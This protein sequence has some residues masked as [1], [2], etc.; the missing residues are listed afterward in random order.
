MS[1]SEDSTV[2]VTKT[3]GAKYGTEEVAE[4][5]DVIAVH[6]FET[7]TA[8]VTVEYGATINLGNFESVRIGVSVTVPCYVEELDQTYEFAQAWAEA[9]ITSERDLISEKRKGEDSPF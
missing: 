8:S 3:I 9:R 1:R 5:S 7:A 4:S 2:Y 6:K